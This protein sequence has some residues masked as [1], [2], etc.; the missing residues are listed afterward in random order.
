VDCKQTNQ[1]EIRP[2]W[3]HRYPPDVSTNTEYVFSVQV[4]NDQQIIL[5]E[6]SAFSWLPKTQA[7]EKVWSETNKAAIERFVPKVADN[8]DMSE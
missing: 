7:I 4:V 5:T 6:H 1:Y 3:R 8:D 2:R